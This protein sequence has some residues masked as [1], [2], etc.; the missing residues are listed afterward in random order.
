MN[1]PSRPAGLALFAL[2]IAC[3]T[4]APPP[5]DPVR[6]IGQNIM[7]GEDDPDH[8]SVVGIVSLQGMGAGLCSGTLI[9]PNLVL[10]ARHCVAQTEE[11]V[12][13]SSSTFGSTY[14][15]NAFFITTEW[16][17][18]EVAF[19]SYQLKGNWFQADEVMVSN[20]TDV[21]G[22]DI[23]LIRLEG[24]G[25]P[26]SIATP[27]VP[28]VDENV[29]A[30]EPYVAHGF[31]A[32]NDQGSGSGRRRILE[33]L[34]VSCVGNCPAIYVENETEWEGDRGICQGDSGGPALDLQGRVIGVV[35]RG[36]TN[37]TSPIYGS[38]FGWADWIQE[39]ALDAAQ[40]G[41]YE[42]APWVTGGGTGGAA[43]AGGAGGAAG[44]AG[45][46]GEAGAAGTAGAAGGDP[47]KAG[48]GQACTQHVDCESG[49]C[50]YENKVTL[51]CSTTCSPAD[52]SCP[53]GFEC[54][55]EIGACFM[56]GGFA[57][58][59]SH[60]DQCRSRMCVE[61]ANGSY[62]SQTCTSD[63]LCPAPAFCDESLGACFLPEPSNT[64]DS[65][66]SSGG[67]AIAHVDDP[68]KPIPWAIGLV[69]AALA[70]QRRRR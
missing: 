56:T 46:G 61:D 58:E 14:G 31:G 13:C 62:C 70:Y 15:A 16:D 17:G 28:R 44:E 20:L 40:K 50:V 45:A 35:S 4:E 6:Y 57:A 52:P 19:E 39:K 21:C 36:G 29:M 5:S 10:T 42:P 67:C 53:E 25:V 48:L 7:G 68:T 34:Y 1:R 9:A 23:A 41:G 3:S 59:C 64:A 32:T 11:Q 8:P 26:S 65:S 54:A 18:P 66:G 63:A 43:G 60:G 49:L 2:A 51:Y 30:G 24:A 38:V 22:N 55:P 33:G 27:I 37:C 69:L 12:M 47:S